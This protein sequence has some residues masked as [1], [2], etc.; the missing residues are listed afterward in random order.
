[1]GAECY[2]LQQRAVGGDGVAHD[3]LWQRVRV[4][5]AEQAEGASYFPR[6]YEDHAISE[7][8]DVSR[9]RLSKDR[10]RGRSSIREPLHCH[11]SA[12]HAAQKTL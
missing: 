7:A 12:E 4:S 8:K 10:Q 9:Q 3:S 5:W 1:M 2:S 11:W 6:H